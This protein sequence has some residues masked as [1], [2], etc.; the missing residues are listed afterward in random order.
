MERRIGGGILA[1]L[2][3][4][5]PATPADAKH[6]L[7]KTRVPPIAFFLTDHGS[8]KGGDSGEGH[9][10]VPRARARG[11]GAA[12]DLT[13]YMDPRE[14]E[15]TLVVVRGPYKRRALRGGDDPYDDPSVYVYK[16]S[17]G[18]WYDV[19]GGAPCFAA[20]T[21]VAT[22]EGEKPIQSLA[23]G[24]AILAW[25]FAEHDLVVSTV[26]RVKRRSKKPTGTLT[27]SDGTKLE[28][29]ANH[30]FYLVPANAWIE[31]GRLA[32]GAVVARRHGAE[33]EEARVVGK[34]AFDK[35]TLVFDVTV[36]GYHD[37]FA[38]GILVH[39]Y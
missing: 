6:R 39:N 31:A 38:G 5:L 27:F 10:D 2:M 8:V 29:T 21:M 15:K 13:P 35:A 12:P 19:D 1:A 4:L 7:R 28:V 36:R 9:R 20:G 14:C 18:A 22:P 32:E 26:D 33:L 11:Q 3:C 16:G 17:D 30:P 37:Y 34:T 23:V 25:D 24:D